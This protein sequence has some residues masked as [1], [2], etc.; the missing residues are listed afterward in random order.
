MWPFAKRGTRASTPESVLS[1][2]LD[3]AHF[4]KNEVWIKI[5]LPE[6]LALALDRLSVAHDAS[7][8]DVLRAL[9]FEYVYGRQELEALIAW[10]Q[11]RDEKAEEVIVRQREGS[12]SVREGKRTVSIDLFGKAT[13]DIKLFLPRPLKVEI[14]ILANMDGLGVSDYVRKTLVRMLLGEKIH[15]QW[16]A[17]VG[18]VPADIQ[19]EEA[20][21]EI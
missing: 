6:K 10:N 8:P 17:A 2:K 7:R 3:Y 12:Y 16:Q 13:E 18:N 1:S 5:W 9:L 11:C 19:L 21:E 14:V 20:K 15:Q 4:E